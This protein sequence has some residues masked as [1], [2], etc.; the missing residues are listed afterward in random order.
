MSNPAIWLAIGFLGQVLFSARFLVQWLAS[1]RARRS[2][3]PIAFWWLSM[4]GSL[5]LL[6]YAASR[7]DPVII[8]GQSIGLVV[9]SRNLILLGERK[10][11][12]RGLASCRP[13]P[14][15]NSDTGSIAG[16]LCCDRVCSLQGW[17]PPCRQGSSLWKGKAI[18][19]SASL[20]RR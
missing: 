5:V 6:V 16:E 14:E 12:R 4:G 7:R 3:V 8:M 15:E 17:T 20:G 18:S 10:R 19:S 9:Y 11:S 2:V 13:S 1:E